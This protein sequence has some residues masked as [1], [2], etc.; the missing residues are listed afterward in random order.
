MEVIETAAAMRETRRELRGR[1]GLVPTLG[2][3]HAGHMALL[4]CA[5]SECDRVIGSL[6][7]NP[8]QFG[9]EDDFLEYPRDRER[10]LEIF[11]DHGAD[12]VFAPPHEEMY[13]EGD[14]TR[15]TPGPLGEILE[16]AS[17]PD[18]FTGVA[19]VVTKLLAVTRPDVAVFGEKDA[20]QLRIIRRLNADLLFGVEIIAVPTIRESDGLAA[21]SR[22]AGLQGDDRRAAS[23]LYRALMAA[24]AMWRT[25]YRSPDALRDRA[26]EVLGTEPRALVDYVSVADPDTLQE[27]E[28]ECNATLVSV[29]VRIGAVRLIDNVLLETD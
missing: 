15:V 26:L 13:L 9:P 12:I 25:G 28:E 1:V 10:D 5:R 14:V 4:D 27:L 17:R 3:L 22:N 11:A 7:V 23:I 2:A 24:S 18:H 6:F 21:S 16:G 20:Q 29:A 8:L 19:T